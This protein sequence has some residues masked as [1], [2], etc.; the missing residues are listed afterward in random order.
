MPASQAYR[1]SSSLYPGPQN[2]PRWRSHAKDFSRRPQLVKQVTYLAIVLAFILP[3]WLY[4]HGRVDT[5]TT[6]LTVEQPPEVISPPIAFDVHNVIP[7][8]GHN[9]H[10]AN[11]HIPSA[12][13]PESIAATSSPLSSFQALPDPVTF[14]F[15]MW[16]ESSAT[17]GA[18]LIKSI[19]MYASGPV[20]IHIICDDSARVLIKTRL[21]RLKRPYYE[22]AVFFH[23]L[24]WQSIQDRLDREGSIWSSHSAGA[25]GLLKLFIHE[26]LPATVEKAIYVDTDAFFI[27]NPL[28]LWQ[29][30][31]KLKADTA[32][33]MPSHPN[34]G[35]PEWYNA[36]RICSCV[37]LLN[38]EK[39]RSIR[40]I[41]SEIYRQANDGIEAMSPPAFRAMFGEVDPK[42]GHYENIALGDQSYWWSIISYRPE[43]Y[44][45]LSYDW[46]ISSCLV[47]T[48]NTALGDDMTTEEE[49]IMSLMHTPGTPHEGT[50]VIPKL[51]HFNCIPTDLYYDWPGWSDPSEPLNQHWGPAVRYH[52][53]YKWIWLN[54]AT[55]GSS[56]Q[57]ANM[58]IETVEPV[59]F[60]DQLYLYKQQ[61][62]SI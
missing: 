32:I 7:H 15:V 50:L 26:I 13:P 46:E 49:E 19:L 55:G 14:A 52:Q 10:H 25:A 16:Q 51:L 35:S 18:L 6:Q 39:L 60:A 41:D 54:R 2:L 8:Y 58:T 53:N 61:A 28:L 29:Q 17:E 45:H 56:S 1:D 42:T 48:Y 43:L 3:I 47:N 27:S 21:E 24:P 33:A 11:I 4:T 38:L 57:P 40:L 36:D 23:V 22:I 30:F 34:L 5:S 44:E 9:S 62:Q 59:L 37:I 31:D 12:P 20:H